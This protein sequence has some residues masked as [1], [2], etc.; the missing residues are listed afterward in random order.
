MRKGNYMARIISVTS[1]KGGVGKTSISVNLAVYL[2]GIGYRVCLFDA[3]LGLANANILLGLYP[4]Y[5]LKDVVDGNM[6]LEDIIIKDCFGIDIIPGSSGIEKMVNIS[7]DRLKGLAHSFSKLDG[8][9]MIVIDTSAGVAKSVLSFCLASTE[10]ILTVTHDPASLTDAYALVKILSLN[11]Y[12]GLIQ[13][14]VNQCPNMKTAQALFARFSDAVD[15]FLSARLVFLGAIFHDLNVTESSRRQ[16]PF[17]ICYPVSPASKCIHEIAGKLVLRKNKNQRNGLDDFLKG[18]LRFMNGPLKYSQKTVIDIQKESSNGRGVL[19]GKTVHDMR[20][21][22][23]QKKR[24]QMPAR[25]GIHLINTYFAGV[26]TILGKLSEGMDSIADELGA[27]RGMMENG[28]K[29]CQKSVNAAPDPQIERQEK[30]T[31]D[32]EAYIENRNEFGNRL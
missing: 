21:H 30:V 3:D 22:D 2:A 8:Y 23:I 19:N 10:I 18:F 29:R 9:D 1:G 25:Q 32:F 20:T 16:E 28:D 27:I 15:K 7:A 26:H 31:L 11:E 14:V 5:D 6:T 4:D 13:V 24:N 12:Q 17:I